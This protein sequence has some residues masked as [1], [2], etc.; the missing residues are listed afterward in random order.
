MKQLL[1][2]IPI[3]LFVVAYKF[4]GSTITLGDWRYTLDGIFS[5]T[6]VLMI[7]TV[8][9]VALVWLIEKQLEKR[10]LWT[11][12][13]VVIFGSATLL[14]RDQ[15]FIQWKPSVFNWG[16]AVAFAVSQFIGDRNLLERIMGAHLA[17]PARI[18][19]RLCWIWVAH[20]M[21]VGVL[22]LVVAYRFSE[23]TW[24]DYK[25]YSGFAFTLFIMLITAIVVSPHIRGETA[26]KDTAEN[27]LKP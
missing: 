25:L 11:G 10:L 12:L 16:M 13:A 17:L 21:T 7:A 1:E 3:I 18:W 27:N 26:G 22:N 19:T 5:A 20:F 15:T 6:A 14:L 9:Q 4:D 24:V 23:A 2:F 8:V